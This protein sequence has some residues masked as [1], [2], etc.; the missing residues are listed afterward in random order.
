MDYVKKYESLK[1]EFY[2]RT[3]KKLT[4]DI[5]HEAWYLYEINRSNKIDV[6]KELFERIIFILN[7]SDLVKVLLA[8]SKIHDRSTFYKD[9]PSYSH[10]RFFIQYAVRK[11]KM[12]S[13]KDKEIS[14]K[15]DDLIKQTMRLKNLI[16][17]GLDDPRLSDLISVASIN[18]NSNENARHRALGYKK[19]QTQILDM[20]KY[21]AELAKQHMTNPKVISHKSSKKLNSNNT[22]I[23]KYRL[24]RFEPK[25]DTKLVEYQAT[26]ERFYYGA[27]KQHSDLLFTDLLASFIYSLVSIEKGDEEKNKHGAV[28][29]ISAPYKNSSKYY[30]TYEEYLVFERSLFHHC[31]AFFG[32]IPNCVKSFH[33]WM[34]GKGGILFPESQKGD[35]RSW[36]L[37][38]DLFR[39]YK[40]KN[41]L[42][43][44]RHYN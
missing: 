41:G 31:E 20:C 42:P 1:D 7:D 39:K 6:N 24:R 23:K 18:S 14:E 16:D 21:Y 27:L 8:L 19:N 35:E 17:R 26:F 44:Q 28:R 25:T 30:N 36:D 5:V 29:R 15:R 13:R 3:S 38:K 9:N 37:A 34:G 12:S 11:P 4:V 33:E 40:N 43:L 10:L 2:D 22:G 32:C